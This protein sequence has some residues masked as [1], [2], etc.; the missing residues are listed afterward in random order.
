MDVVTL[1]R[2]TDTSIKVSHFDSE[3]I[4]RTLSLIPGKLNS[5]RGATKYHEIFVNPT[6]KILVKELPTDAQY[7]TVNITV[8]KK[9]GAPRTGIEAPVARVDDQED[10]T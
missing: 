10:E 9:R 1:L 2:S 7:G 5:L 4:E 3:E 6:G 8:K